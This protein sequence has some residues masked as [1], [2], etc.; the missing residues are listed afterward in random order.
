MTPSPA[1]I[2]KEPRKCVE[3]FPYSFRIGEDRTYKLLI[4]NRRP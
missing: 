2:G 3:T 4:N 1:Q